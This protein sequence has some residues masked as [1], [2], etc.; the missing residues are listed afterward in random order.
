MISA[1]E[2]GA[3]VRKERAGRQSRICADAGSDSFRK[4]RAAAR[5]SSIPSVGCAA[6]PT[7]PP[8]FTTGRIVLPHGGQ[9][10]SGGLERRAGYPRHIQRGSSKFSPSRLY[11]ARAPIHPKRPYGLTRPVVP[12]D[13]SFVLGSVSPSERMKPVGAIG[14]PA[15][16]KNAVFHRISRPR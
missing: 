6:P 13:G 2:R 15:M 11:P 10:I 8:I 9:K 4:S 1:C 5:C 7:T 3:R 14:L 12:P 16:D